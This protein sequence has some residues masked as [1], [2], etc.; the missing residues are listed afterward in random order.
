MGKT[1][2]VAIPQETPT[3]ATQS[4]SKKI[5]FFSA[6]LIVM[7][8]SIGAGI[9]F[10]AKAVLENAQ[11]SLIMAI[12]SWLIAAFAVV[13]MALALVEIASARNDNLSLI[14]WCK[15]FNS[16]SIYKA[17]KNFMF[18]IY[19]PLTYFFM[20]LYVIMSL[21]DAISAFGA[22][23]FDPNVVPADLAYGASSFN[24]AGGRA[25]WV[26]WTLIGLCISIFFIFVSGMSSKAGNIMN[27]GIMAIKFIPLMAAIVIGFIIAGMDGAHVS[28]G[29]VAPGGNISSKSDMFSFAST[30]PG[31][32]LFLAIGGIFF[33]YDGFYVTAG[34]QSEMKEPKKTPLA[35]VFGLGA[36]TIIYLLI[37]IAM[38]ITGNGGLFG[39]HDFLYNHNVIW[40][41][42]VL[43]L[44][45]AIGVLGIINGFA[46]WAPRFIEDLIAENELPFSQ[47]YKNR[48]CAN[49]P[50][51][52][53]YYQLVISIPIILIF[54]VI[55]AEA[56]INVDY[57]SA[58][59]SDQ[60][61]KLY[62]FC[63]LTGTWT[64]VFAFMFIAFAIFGGLK[65]RKDHFVVTEQKKYFVWTGWCSV[66]I[67]ALAI[68][69]LLIEPF[70][71]V[72]VLI[73]MSNNP[74][75]NN[76]MNNT[77]E[78]VGRTMKLV[79]LFIFIGLM[80]LPTVIEDK[81]HVKKYGSI[82]NYEKAL[83]IEPT[84]K[85]KVAVY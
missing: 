79:M 42:G 66:I 54:S 65:N 67:M 25:D 50:M 3:I 8:S 31:I 4:T 77:D 44:T 78:I 10:K 47:K 76:L 73:D 9:F 13:C 64:A 17:S 63:D 68:L 43:N 58:Y 82:E 39:F 32:G 49:K 48:L 56:Y 34:L 11:G 55:G 33:A 61:G 74:A 45:I 51:I 21:Q 40:V 60:M 24:I 7:G 38:S 29:P 2:K 69:M 18:Y 5:S 72:F 20:P 35:I 70:Y 75:A 59:G 22:V 15:V 53:I 26:I 41:F 85:A 52:G 46:M 1:D 62:Q 81:I 83:G 16:R 6:M 71:N 37:A 84:T 28:A 80:V 27:K 36:V 12:I 57:G 30:T 23:K 19:V 14:G